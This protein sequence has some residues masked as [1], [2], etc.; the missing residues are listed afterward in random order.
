MWQGGLQVKMPKLE[1]KGEGCWGVDP[2][3]KEGKDASLTADHLV[4]ELSEH[5]YVDTESK[6]GLLTCGCDPEKVANDKH[7]CKRFRCK[8]NNCSLLCRC[9]GRC[10]LAPPPSAVASTDTDCAGC[11]SEG[12][13]EEWDGGRSQMGTVTLTFRVGGQS[14]MRQQ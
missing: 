7:R 10:Y 14:Q 2:K 13:R 3:G 5:C 1:F 9:E 12:G 8:E 11:N 6:A 4:I